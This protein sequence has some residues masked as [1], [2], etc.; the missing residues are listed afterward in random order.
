MKVKVDQEA[1]IGCGLCADTCPAVF[2]L[3]D[4]KWGHKSSL[5]PKADIKGNEDCIRKAAED[6]PV[7]AIKVSG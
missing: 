4:T 7:Q 2:V 3:V 6:C 5:K 1:C